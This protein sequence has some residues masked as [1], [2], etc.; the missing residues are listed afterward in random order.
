MQSFSRAAMADNQPISRTYLPAA[1]QIN[2]V[3]GP[4]FVVAAVKLGSENGASATAR[5]VKGSSL[6]GSNFIGIM[7]YA[8]LFC[9]GMPVFGSIL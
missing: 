3:C 7:A 5:L 1:Q 4:S 2:I 9:V 6:F 8:L